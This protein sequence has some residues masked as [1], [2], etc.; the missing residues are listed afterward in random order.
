[1]VVLEPLAP[2][3]LPRVLAVPGLRLSGRRLSRFD[4]AMPGHP[5][6]TVAG[7]IR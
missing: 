4:P 3:S 6:L 5:S 2:T 7:D 1:M